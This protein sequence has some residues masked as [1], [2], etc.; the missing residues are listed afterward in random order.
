MKVTNIVDELCRY[1]GIPLMKPFTIEGYRGRFWFDQNKL[2]ENTYGYSTSQSRNIFGRLCLGKLVIH[3]VE[4]VFENEQEVF[5]Y[6]YQEN[7]VL[8]HIF[9]QNSTWDIAMWKIGLFF[10]T[11]EEAVEYGQTR[12]TWLRN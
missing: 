4:E 8:S 9:N 1:L 11:R 2:L 10:S 6:D 5:F 7:K 3:F 12:F